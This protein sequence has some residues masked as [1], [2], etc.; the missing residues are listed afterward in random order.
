MPSVSRGLPL[1]LTLY[2]K[3]E[4][5]EHTSWHGGEPANVCD[6]HTELKWFSISEMYLLKNVVDCNYPRFAQLAMT[7]GDL[8]E[9]PSGS[10]FIFHNKISYRER[11]Q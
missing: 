3:A 7:G 4:L 2:S 1:E 5:I 6:E 8:K 10:H 11:G 9:T